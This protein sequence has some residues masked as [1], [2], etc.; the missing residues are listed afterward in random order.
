MSMKEESDTLDSI[1]VSEETVNPSQL[2]QEVAD[3]IENEFSDEEASE[4]KKR[5]HLEN[6]NTGNPRRTSTFE[7]AKQKLTRLKN[8]SVH[9]CLAVGRRVHGI[10]SSGVSAVGNRVTNDRSIYAKITNVE[11]TSDG[12]EIC[13]EHARFD[14]EYSFELSDG[15]YKLSNLVRYAGIESPAELKGTRIPLASIDEHCEQ[16]NATSKTLAIPKNIS[17]A[18]HVRFSVLTAVNN[19]RANIDYGRSTE[20][21]SKYTDAVL[22]GLHAT[23]WVALIP[24]MAL[25]SFPNNNTLALLFVAALIPFTA[26]LLGAIAGLGYLIVHFILALIA[27]VLSGQKTNIWASTSQ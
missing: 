14:R 18:S 5:V 25:G 17:L 3:E 1:E 12:V 24:G 26:F 8:G 7:V 11:P 19:L 2:S 20:L 10:V 16:R 6:L 23:A 13:F 15:S 27:L 21:K 4:I 22:S 9:A